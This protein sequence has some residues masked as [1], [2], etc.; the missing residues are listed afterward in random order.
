MSD[1]L[2][3]DLPSS[4]R[5]PPPL[6]DVQYNCFA[7]DAAPA[8]VFFFDSDAAAAFAFQPPQRRLLPR[9]AAIIYAIFASQLLSPP[10]F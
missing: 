5:L 10:T 2:I 9:Y 3:A 1:E 4:I 6:Y 8:P 7:A